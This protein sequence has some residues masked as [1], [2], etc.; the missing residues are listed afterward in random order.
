VS[1]LSPAAPARRSWPRRCLRLVERFF[2]VFGLGMLIYHTCF[3]ITVMISGSMAPSLQGNDFATGDRVLV[4]KISRHFRVPRRW[5]IHQFHN[6]EGQSVA[7]RIVGLPG[8]RLALKNGVLHLNGQPLPLPSDLAHLRYHAYGNL[9]ANQE[10]DCGEG[11][12]V[13]G[14]DSRD[15]FDS[16][17]IGVITADDFEGRAWIVL[18]PRAHRGLVR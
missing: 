5:E 15:S 12:Y 9:A 6:A 3:E 14:D 1:A 11:Y 4:E 7:K 2:A 13:L 18:G 16:R 8:E 10:V 17:Y